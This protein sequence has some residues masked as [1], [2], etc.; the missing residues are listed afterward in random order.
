MHL[1]PVTSVNA[2]EPAWRNG[3]LLRDDTFAA[4]RAR[5]AAT[6]EPA[7]HSQSAL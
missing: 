4:K 2:Q 1:P 7:R 5:V 3:E 6:D